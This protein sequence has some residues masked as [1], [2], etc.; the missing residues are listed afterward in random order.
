M[1]AA[2]VAKLL[3]GRLMPW[4]SLVSP[5]LVYVCAGLLIVLPLS[6]SSTS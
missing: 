6:V 5:F 2:Y 1:V 3:S 4:S